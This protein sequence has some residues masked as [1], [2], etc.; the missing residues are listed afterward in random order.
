MPART[1]F[2]VICAISSTWAHAAWDLDPTKSSINFISIKKDSIGEVHKFKDIAGTL[3]Q[4]GEFLI[5]IDLTSVD[6]GIE[7]RDQRMQE[8]FFDIMNFPLAMA[9]G[10]VDA[11][12]LG[13]MKPGV[14]TPVAVDLAI[15]LHGMTAAVTAKV[16]AVKLSPTTLWVTSEV[17]VILNTEDFQLSPGVDK[18]KKL[19]A[20]PSISYAVPV[21]INLL[22]EYTETVPIPVQE[23]N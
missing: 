7:I 4:T 15:T 13:G 5:D 10:R 1:L 2:A 18:L 3:S 12:V 6:T 9:K 23:Q 22:F 17:P 11:D 19:A 8:D 21:A 16:N 20:L 14:V